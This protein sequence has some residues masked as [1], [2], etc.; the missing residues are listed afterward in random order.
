M[1]DAGFIN[2]HEIKYKWAMN[3]WPE[4]DKD[5]TVGLW[6]MTNFLEGVSGFSMAYFVRHLGWTPEDVQVFL[7]DVR[8]E[9]KDTSKHGYF[10][11]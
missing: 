6:T 8:K 11:M 5:K 1:V 10:P 7:V 4:D 9:V 3:T 2:V